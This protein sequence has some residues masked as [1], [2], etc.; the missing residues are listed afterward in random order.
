MRKIKVIKRA[1]RLSSVLLC[2]IL[3][4]G[5]SNSSANVTT[6][7][8]ASGT[9]DLSE[10][11]ENGDDIADGGGA[12]SKSEGAD[13]SEEDTNS[14]D[15]AGSKGDTNSND[16]A[17]SKD[18][19]NSNDVTESENTTGSSNNNLASKDPSK[20]VEHIKPE[21]IAYFDTTYGDY[22]KAG[23]GEAEFLHAGRYLAPCTDLDAGVVYVGTWNDDT[24]DYPLNDDATF[25][26]LEGGLS[27]FFTGSIVEMPADVFLDCLGNEYTVTAEYR[28]SA[29]TAYYVSADEFLHIELT[30]KDDKNADAV[31]EI[32]CRKGETIT[33]ES[34]SWLMKRE[35]INLFSEI[36]AD[37]SFTSGAGAWS[38]DIV[39]SE[40]GSFK[41][42]Y[43]DADMGVIG[44]GYPNG[45]LYI[46]NF[47]GKFSDPEPTDKENIYSTKLLELNIEDKDKIGTEEIVDDTLYVY[48]SPYGFEDADDF[49]IYTPG[50]D[51]SEMSEACQSWIFLSRDIFSEVP[52]DY[53]VIYNVG[54]EEAFTGVNEDS[55]WYSKFSYEYKDASVKFSPSYYMGSYLNF[56]D[57]KDSPAALALSVP[58][59][60]VN[61][62]TMEAKKN[63]S[64]DMEFFNV[65]IEK[66]EDGSE[67]TKYKVTVQSALEEK[68]DF[69]AWGSSTP[70]E[71]SAVFEKIK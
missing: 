11:P 5:C 19:I 51:M 20:M 55:L 68:F 16:A 67:N 60:G 59:D 30:A 71:F 44:E 6:A 14:N 42:Q 31:L 39:I 45:T 65:T 62:N 23:G 17:E 22:V 38:T 32:D 36:P 27:S 70:G 7:S 24:F 2:A 48:S 1:G 57:G 41:G 3:M 9:F 52:A 12:T 46:C 40:D 4:M 49:L 37:F 53:Y 47:S 69:S 56:F 43:Y 26:R 25:L 50:A 61:S 15:A 18:D 29:G 21:A 64:D 63:W 58:W 34:Y 8:G 33:P 54:G 10:N 35:K 13:E 66:V 28:E